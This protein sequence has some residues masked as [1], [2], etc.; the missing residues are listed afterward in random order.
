[1][2]IAC[3]TF[4]SE[5]MGTVVLD[6][7]LACYVDQVTARNEAVICAPDIEI[8]LQVGVAGPPEVVSHHGLSRTLRSRVNV[9]DCL[10]DGQDPS[11]AP[12]PMRPMTQQ[13]KIKQIPAEEIVSY[14]DNL[15]RIEDFTEIDH[16]ALR[17]RDTPA[18]D[19]RDVLRV[20]SAPPAPYSWPVDVK[21]SRQKSHFDGQLQRT[22][23]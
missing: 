11:A 20:E 10:T 22:K 14:S 21:A 16:E 12:Q 18:I 15:A 1:M 6:N 2:S 7:D 8:G 4:T 19:F 5:V 3:L 9:F 23:G 17:C 13:V